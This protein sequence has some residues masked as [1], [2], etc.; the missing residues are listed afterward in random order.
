MTLLQNTLDVTVNHRFPP[1]WTVE[2]HNDAC[3]IVKE[4]TRPARVIW[5]R[6]DVRPQ[7][8]LYAADFPRFA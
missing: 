3:F 2:D 4:V 1:P 6:S 7:L 8:A 5:G